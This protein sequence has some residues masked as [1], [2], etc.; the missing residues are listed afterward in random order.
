MSLKSDKNFGLTKKIVKSPKNNLK[1]KLQNKLILNN[2]NKDND[3]EPCNKK[4]NREVLADIPVNL[5][6]SS[7]KISGKMNFFINCSI[8]FYLPSFV[9]KT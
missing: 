9:V 4:S 6:E 1:R 2:E 5:C 8:I 7:S 3:S